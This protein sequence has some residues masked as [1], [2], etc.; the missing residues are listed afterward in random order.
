VNVFLARQAIYHADRRIHG[1]ELLF[2]RAVTETA[3]VRDGNAATA[4][5]LLNAVVDIGLD[6]IST[7]LPLF[8]NCTRE[9]LLLEP[10]LPPDRCVLEVLEDVEI[11]AAVL[12]R[13]GRLRQQGYRIALDDFTLAGKQ[14]AAVALADYIKL[15]VLALTEA[16]LVQHVKLRRPGMLLIAEKVDSESLMEH[17]RDLG[18]DL[19][20]GYFLR[21]PETAER[22]LHIPTS[23]LAALRLIGACQDP[24]ASVQEVSA[25]VSTDVS[26]TYSLLRLANSALFGRS[27]PVR[28]I[29]AVVTWMGTEYLARWATLLALASERGCPV[30][31]LGTALQRGY[32]CESLAAAVG[33]AASTSGFL[34]GLLSTL[35]SI[36]DV[37]MCQILEQLRLTGD[38]R[39]A[40]EQHGGELGQLLACT[41]AYEC[42]D[43]KTLDWYGI[44]DGLLY[45]AYW[46]SVEQAE[47]T[48]RELVS[49]RV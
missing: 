17:C 47:T 4:Q 26:M 11:D 20:Q 10:F 40:L 39:E 22:R 3:D 25:T 44:D 16:E 43:T 29:E 33:E 5:V 38:I 34:V 21:H 36:L 46:Q 41:L 6:K 14:A 13:I 27:R 49:L 32:M 9:L 42:G 7:T 28:S 23:K 24:E 18:F 37:P 19:F 15:D 35:D 12:E 31:Y 30:T 1:Y 45:D 48:L 2:R 8:I